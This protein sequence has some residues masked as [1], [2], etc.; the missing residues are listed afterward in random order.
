MCVWGGRSPLLVCSG[1]GLFRVRVCALGAASGTGRGRFHL[2]APGVTAAQTAGKIQTSLCWA[3]LFL[4]AWLPL[5]DDT[6]TEKE[7]NL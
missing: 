2:E 1:C 3:V 4:S 5:V 7:R 6:L